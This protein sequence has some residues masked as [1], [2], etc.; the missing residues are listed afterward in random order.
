MLLKGGLMKRLLAIVGVILITSG[1][2]TAQQPHQAG[3]PSVM[4]PPDLARVLRD[5]E[6]AWVKRDA[7]A[8]SQLFVGDG[9]VLP[10][11]NPPVRGRKAIEQFYTGRGGPL[12][13]RAIAYA[14]EGNIAYII[15]GYA[16]KAGDPD[17]GKFT[18]TLRK[19]DGGGWL[20]VSDMD[21]SNRRPR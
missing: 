21:N 4:L 18:L 17:D 10:N 6:A 8:L 1:L 13:L 9:Y 5:Y 3:E 19:T 7:S 16:A 15:G 2:T 12:A 20:I 11:G 14:A